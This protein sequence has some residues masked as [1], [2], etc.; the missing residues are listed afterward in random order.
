MRHLSQLSAL[1]RKDI[2]IE[3]KSRETII[4]MR[5]SMRKEVEKMLNFVREFAEKKGTAIWLEEIE[6]ILE[7]GNGADE[8]LGLAEELGNDLVALQKRMISSV[9]IILIRVVLPAPLS[10]KIAIDL[11]LSRS[12]STSCNA[13]R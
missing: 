11:P 1:L 12:R 2:L 6:D 5:I 7:N 13:F 3:L 9:E 8:M 4:S 10:P